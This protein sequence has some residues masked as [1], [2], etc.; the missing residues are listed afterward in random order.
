MTIESTSSLG[1]PDIVKAEG[2]KVQK[3]LAEEE[4]KFGSVGEHRGPEMPVNNE[5]NKAQL[6]AHPLLAKSVQHSGTYSPEHPDVSQNS[7]AQEELK[8]QLLNKPELTNKLS[9]SMQARL[10]VQEK[11]NQYQKNFTPRPS[12]F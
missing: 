2:W 7:E 10:K 9:L 8:N 5:E 4:K 11:E 1:I 12:G 3:Y 6:P